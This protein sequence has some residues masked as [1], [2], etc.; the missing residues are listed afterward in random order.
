MSSLSNNPSNE[1]VL[2]LL[3]DLDNRVG[4]IENHL[5]ISKS[6]KIDAEE[7]AEQPVT[8]IEELSNE[9][10][11]DRLELQIGQFWFAKLGII[12]F[13]IGIAF[14]ISFPFANIPV[15]S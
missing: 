9:E 3:R 5:G 12:I 10:K 14:L 11:E 8:V 6:E 13:F 7:K 1:E 2:N 4:E 15:A